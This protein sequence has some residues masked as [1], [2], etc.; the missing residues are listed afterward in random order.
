MGAEEVSTIK[1]ALTHRQLAMFVSV[2]TGLKALIPMLMAL[3]IASSP[4]SWA[5]ET[6]PQSDASFNG[7]IG[8][9]ARESVPDWPKPVTAPKDAP[10]V[11]VILLDDIGF[12]DTST[13]GG[14]SQTPELDK[15]AA[16]GLR[17]NNFNT[18]SMCSPTRAALLTGRNHHRVG[19]GTIADWAGG[20]PGY[21]SVWKKSTASI[22]EVLRL[23]GYSTA[24]FG[25][26]HNTPDWEVT[27][28]G[29]FDRWPTGLGFEYFYG[30]MGPDG[31]ENQWEPAKLFRNTLPVDPPAPPEQ[32]YHLTTDITNE[33]I[34]WIHI[35]ES[36]AP[37]KP[38]LLY[39]ATGAVHAPHH[40]P[41]EWIDRYRGQFD[42]GWDQLNKEIFARQK[43]LGVIPA[44]AQLTPRPK[45]IP[46]WN[47]LSANQKRLYARQMEVYAGFVAHTDHEVGR[48]L[49]TIRSGP[50][51]DNTLILY[52]V[53]DN[54]AAGFGRLDG[55]TSVG[56]TVETQLP[57]IDELGS[58]E[59]PYNMYSMGWAWAGD[60]P[61][62]YFKT[63]ASHFGG[64]RDPLVVSWPARIKDKGGVRS[65]FTH[66]ND[67]APTLYDVIGIPFPSTV[68]GSAQQ[69]LDGVSFAPTFD[70]VSAPS[71]HHTQYF[72]MMGNRAIYQDGWVAAARHQ[73]PMKEFSEKLTNPDDDRWELYHVAE[74]FSEAH[75]L[76]KDNPEKL[77]E[78]QAIF[79]VEA[80]KNDVYPL[81]AQFGPGKP[82]LTLGKRKFV[83]YPDVPRIPDALVPDLGQSSYQMTADV[84]FPESG[85]EGVIASYGTRLNGFVFYV[86]DGHLIYE[87]RAGTQHD[88]IVSQMT[89]PR[90]RVA[91]RFQY[92]RSKAD[93]SHN[94][95][96]ASGIGRLFINGQLAART[97]LSRVALPREIGLFLGRAGGSPVS[98]AF[99]QPFTFT[100]T[101]E[102]VTVEMQ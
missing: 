69:P 61:F 16:R 42:Q 35:H 57:H 27:P 97:T 45:E 8:I 29:P 55:L 49:E 93:K 65:Q 68:N 86:K 98:T 100:G 85:A 62:Q 95:G 2:T 53:G 36:L 32:G 48:L 83:Y 64:T 28:T 96:S 74:D 91:L 76:A 40:A 94:E 70:D 39:F 82:S 3:A 13:F 63:I 89:L 52:I 31:G 20:Y 14:V 60:T 56:D 41:K 54:G 79:D 102:K 24:A 87:N 26:W 17:Y 43:T 30:F 67:V 58:P 47:T 71:S 6:P 66:V 21:N 75:D 23:N 46:A 7:K 33:A 44:D 5:A 1:L 81:L 4:K 11:V 101:L 50:N 37:D 38:Y 73:S 12:A 25:K 10:N 19:F 77:K 59:I 34:R 18:T 92:E 99:V 78:L 88:T 15:L 80:R 72:E 51:A 22:A 9:T 90:G 84:I